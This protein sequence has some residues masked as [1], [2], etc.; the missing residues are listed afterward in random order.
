MYYIFNKENKCICS[1]DYEP[2]IDDL[3][4]RDEFSIESDKTYTSISTLVYEGGEII[5]KELP[6]KNIPIEKESK[7][8]MSD[9]IE[10]LKKR[11]QELE[12]TIS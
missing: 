7:I 10:M 6:Q 5:E 1:C 2:N 3:K 12:N 9:E 11:I 8:S 4:T